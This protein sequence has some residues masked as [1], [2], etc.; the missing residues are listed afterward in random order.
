MSTDK[1]I[2]TPVTVETLYGEEGSH[3][4]VPREI[5]ER[6]I[7]HQIMGLVE[8]MIQIEEVPR[9]G[10]LGERCLRGTLYVADGW[11]GT[12]AVAE[13][14]VA[15]ANDLLHRAMENAIAWGEE[16]AVREAA[17]AKAE[18]EF[19]QRFRTAVS[20]FMGYDECMGRR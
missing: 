1:A 9:G 3:T 18:A 5:A 17:L 13:R 11:R 14:I 12:E 10:Y 2:I 20:E 7:R 15:E 19:S 16:A 4:H 8:Q 6:R